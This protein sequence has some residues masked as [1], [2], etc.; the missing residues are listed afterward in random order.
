LPMEVEPMP[1]DMTW[2]S[3]PPEQTTA[4]AHLTA[5]LAFDLS[6][7]M[8]GTPLAEAQKAAHEF[9]AQTDLA[10]NSLGIIS[11]ADRVETTAAACQDARKLK[12]AIDSLA[13]GGVGGGNAASP[14]DHTHELLKQVDDP[15]YIIVLTDGMWSHQRA[16]AREAKAC[17]ANGIE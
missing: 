14:F 15:R 2:L 9:V 13:I 4:P 11:F 10:H 7:S 1:A 3:R 17:H 12:K 16:A 5:Y 6:G 8:G